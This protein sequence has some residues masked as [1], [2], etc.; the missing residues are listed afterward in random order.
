ME[1]NMETQDLIKNIIDNIVSDDNVKAKSDFETIMTQKMA[2]ALDA[3]KVEIAQSIYSQEEE[4][5]D[6]PEETDTSDSRDEIS[7]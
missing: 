7:S 4:P 2:D 5:I 1:N 6:E 3:K